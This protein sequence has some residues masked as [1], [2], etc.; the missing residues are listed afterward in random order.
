MEVLLLL[1]AGLAE[2][3]AAT[4]AS[5][6]SLLPEDVALFSLWLACS[7]CAKLRNDF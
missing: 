4:G 2:P 7:T 6:S 1:C 3:A 5:A